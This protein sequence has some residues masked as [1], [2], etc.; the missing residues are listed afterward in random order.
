M[1]KHYWFRK[2][3]FICE[4]LNEYILIVVIMYLHIIQ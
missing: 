3:H 4:N 2:K 1:F